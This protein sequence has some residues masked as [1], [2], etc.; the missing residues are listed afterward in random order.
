MFNIH[1]LHL[2]MQRVQFYKSMT[3]SSK[4]CLSPK[5]RHFKSNNFICAVLFSGISKVCSDNNDNELRK[6][7]TSFVYYFG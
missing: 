3:D 1:C 7:G 4:A 6:L 2:I 5:M